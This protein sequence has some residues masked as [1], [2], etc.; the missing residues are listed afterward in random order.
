MNSNLFALVLKQQLVEICRD[1]IEWSL[2]KDISSTNILW[3]LR[4]KKSMMIFER[5]E[6]VSVWWPAAKTPLSFP[7]ESQAKWCMK[8][9]ASNQ[10]DGCS[11]VFMLYHRGGLPI[12]SHIVHRVT[13]DECFKATAYWIS[14]AKNS[15]SRRWIS[16]SDSET[17]RGS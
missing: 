5:E 9:H 3:N 16:R 10:V 12:W 6:Y 8:E 14:L 1:P 2:E 7:T 13:C 17:E 11:L 4:R 15:F